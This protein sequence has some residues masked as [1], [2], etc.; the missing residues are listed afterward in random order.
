MRP[1]GRPL[2]LRITV[3]DPPP[4][5]AYALQ[6]G[7]SDHVKPTKSTKTCITFDFEVEVVPGAP[8]RLRGPAVQGKPGGRFVYLGVG[9]YAGAGG[10]GGRVKV[11]LEGITQKLIDAVGTTGRLEVRFA[12]TGKNGAPTYASVPLL[13]GGWKVS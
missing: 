12:G 4:G 13:D 1:M 6:L 5:I 8:F 3:I 7:K 10:T 9:S 2:Q 11:N